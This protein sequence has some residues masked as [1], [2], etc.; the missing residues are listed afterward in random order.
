MHPNYDS[1][2]IN[3]DQS[4][5][6][7]FLWACAASVILVLG[8]GSPA[9]GASREISA[10]ADCG[11]RRSDAALA[12]TCPHWPTGPGQ[13]SICGPEPTRAAVRGGLPTVFIVTLYSRQTGSGAE[14]R[15][16]VNYVQYPE[17][18]WSPAR[19]R[20]AG[21]LLVSDWAW[22]SVNLT[23]LTAIVVGTGSSSQYTVDYT[24]SG[25]YAGN[26]RDLSLE[27]TYAA[28]L[29]LTSSTVLSDSANVASTTTSG[30]VPT[31]GATASARSTPAPLTSTGPRQ[32]RP[33]RRSAGNSAVDSGDH[34]NGDHHE[35]GNCDPARGVRYAGD[36]R[37]C[38]R[39]G[40]SMTADRSAGKDR[41]AASPVAQASE[42]SID[43]LRS[44]ATLWGNAVSAQHGDKSRFATH[45]ETLANV[46]S[47]FSVAFA[48]LPRFRTETALRR[49][50]ESL[51]Q[52]ERAL[53]EART[54]A[55]EPFLSQAAAQAAQAARQ[56][57]SAFGTL[58]GKNARVRL[59]AVRTVRGSVQR[60]LTDRG[61]GFLRQDG[62]TTEIFFSAQ[63]MRGGRISDLRV[64]QPVSFRVAPDPRVPGRLHAVDVQ[65]LR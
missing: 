40:T 31:A 46:Y 11:A 39:N 33:S 10:C 51:Q 7:R 29:S 35:R 18:A 61:Y 34:G 63:G 1:E 53:R 43:S 38:H 59:G 65:L 6:S 50:M 44:S 20:D 5:Q 23:N 4:M 37:H 47:A 15:E 42:D 55:F 13:V 30:A 16:V 14:E 25:V 48:A 19:P 49:F 17:Y 27:E 2:A 52:L 54:P 21:T 9:G 36:F 56:A 64:G 58:S 32:R 8:A 60:L 45:A 12:G 41:S 26:S 22:L 3:W 62:E 24:A 57:E 28:D